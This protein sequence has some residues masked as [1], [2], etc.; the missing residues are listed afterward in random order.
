MLN[1]S[2]DNEFEDIHDS[3][4]TPSAHERLLHASRNGETNEVKEMLGQ[5]KL[6]KLD[7]NL[8]CKGNEFFPKYLF[9]NISFFYAKIWN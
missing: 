8:N 7:I 2:S 6:G 1:S 5:Y 3:H 9:H 4:E